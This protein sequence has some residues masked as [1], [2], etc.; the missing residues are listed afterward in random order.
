MTV[1]AFLVLLLVIVG[2]GLLA[3]RHGADSRPGIDRPPDPWWG[4]GR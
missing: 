2:A 1:I 3:P 4:R